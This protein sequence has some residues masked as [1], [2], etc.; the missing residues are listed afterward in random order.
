[1]RRSL[2][3]YYYAPLRY[4]FDSAKPGAHIMQT[5]VR[6]LNDAQQTLIS[7]LPPS[8]ASTIWHALHHSYPT[9]PPPP[10]DPSGP[11]L[12]RQLTAA[13]LDQVTTLQPLFHQSTPA[14]V[15][16]LEEATGLHINHC[17]PTRLH[18]PTQRTHPARTP[19]PKP[20]DNRTIL[21]VTPNP[22]KP[23]SAS[24]IRFAL[25]APGLTI[26]Q[27]LQLGVTMADIKW[28][29]ERSFIVLA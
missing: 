6:R 19:Q 18:T 20:T 23:G 13:R 14:A 5:A 4:Y 12:L 8:R 16:S 1:M 26:S 25:Y 2:F 27:V 10:P 29:L 17:R 9:F 11:D 3:T 22:K 28:D 15:A 7:L 24:F 21:T